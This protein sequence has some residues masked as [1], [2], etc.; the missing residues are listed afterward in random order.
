MSPQEIHDFLE[1]GVSILIGTADAR[2]APEATRGIGAKVAPGGKRV[3][4]Y[5]PDAPSQRTFANLRATGAIAVT[6]SRPSDHVTL[7]L[8]GKAIDLRPADDDERD[9]VE[10]YRALL[11]DELAY[12]G[13]P[14]RLSRRFVFWPCHRIDVAVDAMFV[15]TPGPGAGAPL[16]S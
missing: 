6:F 12:V 9:F 10:R 2:L 7:Q 11:A 16:A 1:S 8:K 3:T 5:V 13:V 14:R 15:Q 4:V